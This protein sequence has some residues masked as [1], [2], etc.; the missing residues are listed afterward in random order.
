MKRFTVISALVVA[1]VV[2]AS[3]F[4][5]AMRADAGQ[6][7][8]AQTA[9]CPHGGDLTEMQSH[10]QA[11]HGPGSFDQMH[12]SDEDGM[13]PGMMSGTGQTMGG[14]MG[15]TAGQPSGGMMR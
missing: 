3:L 1:I 6:A 8:P 12:S 4:A 2:S 5:L 15:S 14:H 13:T 9:A 11:V 10:M 7:A